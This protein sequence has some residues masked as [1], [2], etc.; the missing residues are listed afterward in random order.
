VTSQIN[1]S[2]DYSI[3]FKYRFYRP[4]LS[5]LFPP[6]VKKLAPSHLPFD[7]VASLIYHDGCQ[8]FESLSMV[9]RD[10]HVFSKTQENDYGYTFGLLSSLSAKEF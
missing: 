2:A 5:T 1:I 6:E 10:A 3:H 9:C 7:N 4:D 8:L